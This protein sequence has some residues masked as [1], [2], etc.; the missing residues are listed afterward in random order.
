[1]LTRVVTF[2]LL[3]VLAGC[4]GSSSSVPFIDPAGGDTTGNLVTP[5]IDLTGSFK[6][7]GSFELTDDTLLDRI[8]YRANYME[9]TEAQDAS[10]FVHN[11]PPAV[12]NCRLR[13]TA[14]IGSDIGNISFSPQ[15]QFNLVSAGE[16][17]T[18]TSDAGTYAKVG[19]SDSRLE[20]AAYPVPSNLVLDIPGE[21]FPAFSDVSVPEVV[22][23]AN[24]SPARNEVLRADTTVTWDSTGVPGN[25]IYLSVFDIF[26]TDKIVNLFC[27][28]ADDGEFNLPAD[29]QAALNLSLGAGAELN[30]TK[31]DLLSLTTIVQGD[32]LF[33]VSKV[34][35][36]L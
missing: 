33:V 25:T 10:I 23:A 30:G 9:L 16:N 14:T 5:A 22:R 2:G 11:V 21:V 35:D 32:A 26:A 12:D 18:L 29:V 31:Q 13:I 4:G 36:T 24:F 7:Y 27:R 19:Y 20:I 1:M 3:G 34:L 28:M 8:N 6:F 15:A 17:F